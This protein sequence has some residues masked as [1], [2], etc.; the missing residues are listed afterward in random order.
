MCDCFLC[1]QVVKSS[2]NSSRSSRTVV[3]SDALSATMGPAMSSSTDS[4][5]C[6]SLARY[7]QWSTHTQCVCS[8]RSD[9]LISSR[10]NRR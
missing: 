8:L 10:Q 7:T 5:L 6:I 1:L 9:L 2:S 3:T 4:I